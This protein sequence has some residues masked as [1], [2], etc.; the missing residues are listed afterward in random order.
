MENKLQ[1][2]KTKLRYISRK[3]EESNN[4][5]CSKVNE[6]DGGDYDSLLLEEIV[7]ELEEIKDIAL[8]TIKELG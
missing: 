8:R 1:E 2:I 7:G 5:V 4:K 3:I 6:L